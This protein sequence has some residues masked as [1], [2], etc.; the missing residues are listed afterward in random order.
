MLTASVNGIELSYLL[1]DFVDPWNREKEYLILLHGWT[2]DHRFEDQRMVIV[3]ILPASQIDFE[4][5]VEEAFGETRVFRQLC[6]GAQGCR[7][8]TPL[9]PPGSNYQGDA[10]GSQT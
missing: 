5:Y 9:S 7:Q 1:A 3:H 2:V 8:H 6:D 10:P 4:E